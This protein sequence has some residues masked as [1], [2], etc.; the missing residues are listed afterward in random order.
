MPKLYWCGQTKDK[1]HPGSLIEA[2]H[3]PKDKGLQHFIK[4]KYMMTFSLF[5]LNK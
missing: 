1:R 5:T 2:A 4:G 3:C